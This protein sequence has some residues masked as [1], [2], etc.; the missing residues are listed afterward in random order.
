MN[1]EDIVETKIK[2]FECVVTTDNK[3]LSCNNITN[4]YN[5]LVVVFFSS[6]T[7]FV[8]VLLLLLNLAIKE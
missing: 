6:F 2:I 8:V 7:L 1:T 3:I 5:S 4:K